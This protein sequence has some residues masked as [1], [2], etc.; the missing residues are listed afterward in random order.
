MGFAHNI[1]RTLDVL[2]HLA[3]VA[4]V[5]C[6]IVLLFTDGHSL[7][8]VCNADS[9]SQ[10]EMISLQVLKLAVRLGRYRSQ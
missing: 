6:H 7:E 3:A 9:T 8:A 10:I 4:Q 1:V 5:G 2:D